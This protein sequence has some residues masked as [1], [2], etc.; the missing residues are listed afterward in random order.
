MRNIL[1]NKVQYELFCFLKVLPLFLIP[2]HTHA[3]I[4]SIL[5]TNSLHFPR[6]LLHFPPFIF[7]SYQ[8]NTLP[9]QNFKTFHVTLGDIDTLSRDISSSEAYNN[10]AHVY[11]EMNTDAG[12][13]S[14]PKPETC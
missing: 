11:V 5:P 1:N 13:I 9:V 7:P 6:L 10:N 12:K 14:S 8:K 4:F 2:C 3:H